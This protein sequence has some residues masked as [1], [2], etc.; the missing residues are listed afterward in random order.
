LET[1]RFVVD[2]YE[3]AEEMYFSFSADVV[4]E[5]SRIIHSV[6]TVVL[7]AAGKAALGYEFDDFVFYSTG[8]FGVFSFQFGHSCF[9][10]LFL[11]CSKFKL[12]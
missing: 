8:S 11:Y 10:I 1:R 7:V 3:L 6:D 2:L 5:R 12:S 4:D 9:E